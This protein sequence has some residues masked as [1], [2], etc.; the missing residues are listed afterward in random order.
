[1]R[2]TNLFLAACAIAA[3]ILQCNPACADVLGQTLNIP[4]DQPQHQ[5][6]QPPYLQEQPMQP[7]SQEQDEEQPQERQFIW[8]QKSFMAKKPP[9]PQH[10]TTDPYCFTQAEQR[11][12]VSGQLLR[13]ISK[14]ESNHQPYAVNWN[15]N[16][17][18]DYCHMQINSSWVPTIGIDA[19]NQLSD[20]CYCT[21]VGA[22]ILS[23]CIKSLGYT[24][25]AVGC[26]NAKTKSKAIIYSKK[27]EKALNA[28]KQAK[29]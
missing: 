6:E 23:Q 13:A 11:Y 1:M 7:D 19:W 25:E 17:S 26:Y 10:L 27:V 24:W 22:W 2:Q 5:Q 21:M 9:T 14:V 29:Q 4:D 18:Y 28:L 20:P 12:A 3:I 8:N 15:K 16:K